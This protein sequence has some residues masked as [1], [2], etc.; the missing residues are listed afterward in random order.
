MYAYSSLIDHTYST[1]NQG[2]KAT[3]EMP[4]NGHIQVQAD[5]NTS[6]H[7]SQNVLCMYIHSTGCHT[8]DKLV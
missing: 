7:G 4:G 3:W 6:C 8:N 2:K 5:M 1:K